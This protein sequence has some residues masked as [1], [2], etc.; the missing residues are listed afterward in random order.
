M[1]QIRNA[2]QN[3]KEDM[4]LFYNELDQLKGEISE[5]KADL[6]NIYAI[7]EQI[8]VKLDK[9]IAIL[10]STQNPTNTT[11]STHSSTQN[12]PLKSL[13]AQIK[14]F[15]TGNQGVPTDKQTNRQ[16]NNQ[17]EILQKN[18]QKPTFYSENKENPEISQDNLPSDP[19]SIDNAAMILD[20]LDGIKKELRLKFKRLTEQEIAVF[21]ALYQ[22]DEE[23]GPTDYKTIASKL[24]LTESSI[25]DYIG[26]LIKKGIPVDKKR[27]NNKT[28][29]LSISE[30]LKK[31]ASLPTILQ[32]RDI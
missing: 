13:K 29:M 15:S 26:R 24:N 18:A 6:Y 12:T 27:L 31:I 16:T 21:S 3:V 25:R 5:T 19:T 1:D 14:P 10:A 2:F 9:N 17:Q 20:S 8:N 22:I 23:K 11:D 28:I 30:N 4:D 7:L 32:L